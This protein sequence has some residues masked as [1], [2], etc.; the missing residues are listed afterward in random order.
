MSCAIRGGDTAFHPAG[1]PAILA[2]PEQAVMHDDRVGFGNGGVDQKPC[3]R[4]HRADDLANL[5]FALNLQNRSD[6]NP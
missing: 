1:Q 4:S 2:A 6:H 5:G 3:W